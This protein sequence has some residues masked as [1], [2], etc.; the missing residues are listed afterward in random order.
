[1][2]RAYYED[3]SVFTSEDGP[4]EAAPPYGV[5]GIWQDKEDQQLLSQDYYLFRSDYDCWI[6]VQGDGLVDHLA[7]AARYV[8]ACLVGRAVPLSVWKDTARRMAADRER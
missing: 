4:P 3:G 5:L 2:W 6:E 8:R 1:M 7:H